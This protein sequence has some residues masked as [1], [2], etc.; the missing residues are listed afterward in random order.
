MTSCSYSIKIAHGRDQQWR[1]IRAC[2]YIMRTL[3]VSLSLSPYGPL[4]EVALYSIMLEDIII[5]IPSF[6]FT[7]SAS[8]TNL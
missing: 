1:F 2:A 3:I 4:L 5:I 6:H 7:V 8:S